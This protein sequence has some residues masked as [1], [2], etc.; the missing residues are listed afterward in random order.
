MFPLRNVEFSKND[1]KKNVFLPKKMTAELAEEIG[2]H[3]GDGSLNVYKGNFL[4]SLRGHLKDD[5]KYYTEFIRI[6]YRNLY[7]IDISIRKWPDVIGFQL[8][9]CAIG[10]FKRDILGL[11]L[12][13]KVNVAIPKNI[14]K[15]RKLTL[16]CLRGIFDTDGTLSFEKKSRK[17][18]YY[19]RII[20]STVSKTLNKQI[21][22]ALNK[23]LGFNLSSWKEDYSNRKWNTINRICVRGSENLVKWFELIGSD[24]SKNIFK[25]NYWRIHGHALVAQ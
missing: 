15:N 4:Y 14:L 22:F 20:L 13:S 3:I 21:V 1:V 25:Y 10:Q 23:M 12:G 16:S 5:E 2:I 11:P 6:L 18:P 9:S 17:K 7:G 8:S 19:P 24:N